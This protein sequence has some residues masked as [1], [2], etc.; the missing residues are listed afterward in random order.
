MTNRSEI[1]S[2]NQILEEVIQTD[3]VRQ[4]RI[5]VT[6]TL[7]SEYSLKWLIDRGGNSSYA[8]GTEEFFYPAYKTTVVEQ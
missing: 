7:G 4:E 3:S 1:D 6:Y 2:E 8:N 5:L